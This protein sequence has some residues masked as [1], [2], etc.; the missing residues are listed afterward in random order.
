TNNDIQLENVQ[1][2]AGQNYTVLV[3]N[4]SNGCQNTAVVNVADNKQTPSFTLVSSP[5]TVCDPVLAVLGGGVFDGEIT[6]NI[7]ATG[8]FAG[9]T[10]TDFSFTWSTGV[11]GVGANI[12]SNLDA[13]NYSVTAVHTQTGCESDPTNVQV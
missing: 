13:G 3:T 7:N 12:L 6:A 9:S 8:N 1:G 2:G 10:A 5:V 11:N 4:R